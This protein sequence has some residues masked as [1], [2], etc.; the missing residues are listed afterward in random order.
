M[1]CFLEYILIVYDTIAAAF[2]G[3]AIIPKVRRHYF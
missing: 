3:S 1:P 2:S